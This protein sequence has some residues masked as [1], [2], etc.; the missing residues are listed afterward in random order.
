VTVPAGSERGIRAG[1]D[2]RLE[3]VLVTAPPPTDAEHEP[4]RRGLESGE[5][6]PN[7]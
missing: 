5:F 3:A 4:V 1:E 7:P 2:E 6:D